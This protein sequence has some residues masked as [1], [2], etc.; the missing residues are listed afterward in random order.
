LEFFVFNSDGSYQKYF[1]PE[2]LAANNQYTFLVDA[3]NLTV[4]TAVNQNLGEPSPAPA[5][6]TDFKKNSLY[7]ELLLDG[8]NSRADISTST[9]FAMAAEGTINVV[10]GET[11]TLNLSVRRL[12]SKIE[13]PKVDPS[14]QITAPK[15]DLLKI[16][17]LGENGTVPSDL[18]WTFDGYMVI[19][20]INQSRAFE[21][22]ELEDWTRFATATNFKTTFSMDGET[23]ESVYSVKKDDADETTNGFLPAIYDKPVYV[24]ENVPTTLQGGNGSA[25]TVFDKDE[26]VAFIVRGTF[27]GTGESGVTRY[28]RVNLLKDD[29]WKIYRNS[30]YRI[31]MKD[32][33]T[34]GWS[35]P[36]EAEEEGP[37]VSP[38][39]SSISINIE[40]AQWDVRTQ[41]VDL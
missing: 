25:A 34:V 13:S 4:L 3:G 26:V 36:K 41:D 7:K 14:N 22:K 33:K 9:G 31:T 29:A 11:N 38:T 10:E 20:G 18:K 19:N 32:I 37:V 2:V 12:L 21:Y 15:D 16:L 30:I 8:S 1:K 27:S 24:Y 23:V 35:T 17:G 6:L 5:S 39:E 28:W 40:V